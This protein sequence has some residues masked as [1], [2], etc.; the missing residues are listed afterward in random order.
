MTVITPTIEPTDDG[1]VITWSSLAAG[2]TGAS[3]SVPNFERRDIQLIGMDGNSDVA[4]DG[5][6]DNT[7]WTQLRS[8]TTTPQLSGWI[9]IPRSSM[10]VEPRYVRP[11]VLSGTT[12][13]VTLIMFCSKGVR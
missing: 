13:S 12:V 8:L 9:P 3:V 1:L 5:S 10:S 2:D 4:L 11:A 6:N 7:N